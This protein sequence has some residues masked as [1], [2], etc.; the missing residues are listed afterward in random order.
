MRSACSRLDELTSTDLQ[1]AASVRLAV[2]ILGLICED[3]REWGLSEG[4]TGLS[5]STRP[6]LPTSR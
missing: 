3:S 1:S 2:A 6:W 4:G 5:G